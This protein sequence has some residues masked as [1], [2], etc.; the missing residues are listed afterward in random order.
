M[1][2]VVDFEKIWQRFTSSYTPAIGLKRA[3]NDHLKRAY[4][5]H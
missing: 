3:Y 1:G 4:N 5:D 2:K